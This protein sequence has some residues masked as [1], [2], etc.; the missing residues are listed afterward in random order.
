[1]AL[2]SDCPLRIRA[3]R[4]VMGLKQPDF[5]ALVGVSPITVS[6]WENGQNDPTELG[7]ARILDLEARTTASAA[8]AND[9]QPDYTQMDFGAEPEAVAAVAEA[10][11]LSNGH[12]ASPTFATEISLIDPLPH[13]RAAVYDQI[14]KSWPIRFLLADDAGA[15]K[16]IM[17]GLT[18]RELL[19][20]RMIQRVLIVPPAGL[21]GNWQRE[22]RNLFRI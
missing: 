13:Q 15:G 18:I 10:V 9:S 21:V 20:R 4:R 7:W 11:R 1:M 12:L 2:P 22:L 17:T 8:A 14:L 16:T 19:S 3:L 5:A 6:R